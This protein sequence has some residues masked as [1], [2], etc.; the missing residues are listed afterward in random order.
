[1]DECSEWLNECIQVFPS[2]KAEKIVCVYSKMTPKKL[3]QVSYKVRKYNFV[4]PIEL[5]LKGNCTSKDVRT[6]VASNALI[7]INNRFQKIKSEEMRKLAVQSIIVHELLHLETH[8]N[9]LASQ[10][11][12]K[13]IHTRSFKLTVLNKYNEL[14]KLNNYPEV[15]DAEALDIAVSNLVHDV[16]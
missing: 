2:L 8:S 1:M 12:R 16:F 11:K 10:R 9:L 3:G 6:V 13:R 5:L 14:R 4:D 15:A 7:K